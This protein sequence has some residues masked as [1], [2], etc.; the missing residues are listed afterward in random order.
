MYQFINAL[1]GVLFGHLASTMQN[2]VKLQTTITKLQHFKHLK[3]S[4]PTWRFCRAMQS[5]IAVTNG[6]MDVCVHTSW[7][8]FVSTLSP[9]LCARR[10]EKLQ[11]QVGSSFDTLVRVH[12]RM[13]S[14]AYEWET[15]TEGESS[16]QQLWQNKL[17]QIAWHRYQE[18]IIYI[19]LL[20][21]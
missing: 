1:K 10:A 17:W 18:Y 11:S 12:V 3:I 9:Q 20:L 2:L 8:V 13:C 15:L 4:T 7:W 19:L 14:V 16:H 21:L 6:L 5:C